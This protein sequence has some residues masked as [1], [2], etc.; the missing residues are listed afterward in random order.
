MTSQEP[1]L[2]SG[3]GPVFLA[4]AKRS[5]ARSTQAPATDHPQ[6]AGACASAILFAAAALEA[7]LSEY[8]TIKAESGAPRLP[9]QVLSTVRDGRDGLHTRFER[10]LKHYD[11]SVN[12]QKHKPFQDLRCLV[13]LRNCIAHRKAAFLKLGTWPEELRSCRRRIPYYKNGVYDWTSVLLVPS[14]ATWAIRVADNW[15]AWWMSRVPPI[16]VRTP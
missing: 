14:V 10:L 12:C 1:I 9:H 7:E 3:F 11:S 15:N 8:A 13:A 2:L 5:L 6:I 16:R 4:E